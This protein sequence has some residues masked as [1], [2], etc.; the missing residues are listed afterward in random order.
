MYELYVDGQYIDCYPTK[1]AAVA[2]ASRLPDG[3][4]WHIEYF[5]GQ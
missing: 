2:A 5:S 1:W 4:D 3:V